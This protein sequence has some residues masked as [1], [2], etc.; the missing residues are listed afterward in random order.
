MANGF[1]LTF[2]ASNFQYIEG[3]GDGINGLSEYSIISYSRPQE[4]V[5]AGND[6]TMVW[7]GDQDASGDYVN[8]QYDGAVSGN[9]VAQSEWRGSGG[10]DV[11]EDTNDIDETIF[12]L[13]RTQA[14]NAPL[15]GVAYA[16]NAITTDTFA[17]A[18]DHGGT[19]YTALGR[20]RDSSPS[21]ALEGE[22]L[23]A[24]V[25]NK[26]LT[27]A[28]TIAA[29]AAGM[30]PLHCAEIRDNL[31]HAWFC[32]TLTPRDLVGSINLD[33]TGDSPSMFDDMADISSN[34]GFFGE[35]MI[36]P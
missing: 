10:Q 13:F 11:I 17:D 6:G 34:G 20:T 2:D 21:D 15:R 9:D 12:S 35:R 25:I 4:G 18:P 26:Y 33:E 32:D 30:S 1:G 7:I 19:Q 24:V 31:I 29:L 23:W 27:D 8:Q 5:S 22:I 36:A 3:P 14:T 16:D 28:N